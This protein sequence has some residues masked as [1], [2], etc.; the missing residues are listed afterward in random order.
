M[1]WH[2]S[3]IIFILPYLAL[4]IINVSKFLILKLVASLTTGLSQDTN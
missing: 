1:Y 3:N 4:G 2:R